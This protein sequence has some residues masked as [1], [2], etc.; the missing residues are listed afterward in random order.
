MASSKASEN[1]TLV[2]RYIS[3]AR[4]EE[5][6]ITLK[7]ICLSESSP[8]LTLS[9]YCGGKLLFYSERI[10]LGEERKFFLAGGNYTGRIMIYDRRG[11]LDENVIGLV[12]FS[13]A[14]SNSTF[15]ET[16]VDIESLPLPFAEKIYFNYLNCTPLLILPGK[17]T[18]VDIS[19]GSH[20]ESYFWSW[21]FRNIFSSG[22]DS[23]QGYLRYSSFSI[24][25][26]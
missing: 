24:R 1:G 4:P 5:Q 20:I 19:V 6:E 8:E 9:L 10:K 22:F 2:I 7:Y 26:E 17:K 21:L 3:D 13:D 23:H 18:I 15:C 16:G 12:R 11:I 25:Y 14:N